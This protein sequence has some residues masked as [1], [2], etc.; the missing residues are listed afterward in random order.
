MIP[1]FYFKVSSLLV[2]SRSSP[3]NRIQVVGLKSYHVNREGDTKTVVNFDVH[4]N[5]D[6]ITDL[7]NHC[8]AQP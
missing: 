5:I 6:R 2:F 3:S 8:A 4:R 7:I 1:F